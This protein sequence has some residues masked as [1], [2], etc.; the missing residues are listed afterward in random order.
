VTAV[1][2]RL[3]LSYAA[4]L[5]AACGLVLGSS[6]LLVRAHLER[7]LDEPAAGQA[8][9][10]LAS[11]YAVALVGIALLAVGGGWLV[12]GQVLAP[13]ARAMD[14]QR[15][16]VANASHELR[17]PITA[18]RAGAEVALDDPRPTVDGLRA[19]LRETVATTEETDRLMTSLLA[20]AGATDGARVDEPVDLSRVVR[21]VLPP[22][23]PI[24]AHL[25]PT[26]VRG[27]AALLGRAAAN[28]IENA[29]RHG[30]PGAP[31]TVGVRAGELAVSNRGPVIRAEDLGRLVQPFERLRR[32]PAPG[33]GLGLSI[34]Q[35]IADAHGG[36]LTLE[37]PPDGGLVARLALPAG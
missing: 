31:V 19:V 2:L 30:S 6:Y 18:I 4:L 25:E 36:R 16:F 35:A 29:L 24:T 22:G 14:L 20:L 32:D 9:A 28:L 26:T 11:Q 17:T 13:V 33:S 7:T 5:A 8:V 3:T 34:V 15:R 27:D 12:S 37:A 1:R 23:A 21:A 10:A